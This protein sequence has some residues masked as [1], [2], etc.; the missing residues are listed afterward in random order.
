MRDV[1]DS[2]SSPEGTESTAPGFQPRR[3]DLS[4]RSPGIGRAA[5][6][7][8]K[9]SNQPHT[10]SSPFEAPEVGRFQSRAN[11]AMA[12]PQIPAHARLANP[13]KGG[14]AARMPDPLGAGE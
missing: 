7:A 14:P 8:P 4:Q 11:D 5:E 2:V 1:F 12:N 10:F 9:G 3:G 13:K 6:P